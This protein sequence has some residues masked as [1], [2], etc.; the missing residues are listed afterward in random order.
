MK[1]EVNIFYSMSCFL[2][3]NLTMHFYQFLLDREFNVYI[4]I[5]THMDIKLSS[6]IHGYQLV[7]SFP[8]FFFFFFVLLGPCP[9][10]TEVPR[11][12]VDSELQL[13]PMPQPQQ[14][15][16]QAGSVTY[17]A[18][19]HNTGSLTPEQ[20]LGSSPPASSRMPAGFVKSL[21]HDGNSL[22]SSFLHLFFF[23][24]SSTSFLLI[25]IVHSLLSRYHH[26]VNQH[27]LDERSHC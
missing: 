22:C 14:C 7:S 27:I 5:F 3:P 12:G 26:V 2:F 25:A 13:W 1:G 10:H 17:T 20:C 8:C 18:A 4:F 23:S 11:L 16:I 6:Q 15:G 19:H 24:Y 21:S 9:Q